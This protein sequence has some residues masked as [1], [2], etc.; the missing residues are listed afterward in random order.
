MVLSG[1]T[2]TVN[3]VSWNPQNPSMLASA[4]DDGYVKVW[5]PTRKLEEV[6][7]VEMYANGQGMSLPSSV[8]SSSSS[9]L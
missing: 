8:R 5:G 9:L 4:G 1:H 2:R 3:A 6:P 7:K